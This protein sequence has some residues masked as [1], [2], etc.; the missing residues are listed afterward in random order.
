MA[1]LLAI[2]VVGVGL[3]FAHLSDRGLIYWD[4]GKFGLEGIRLLT[5]GR[6][7]AGAHLPLTLG[8]AVGTAKPGHALLIA[9]AYAI[10]GIHDYAALYLDAAASVLQIWL[11]YLVARRLFNP[12]IALISA[13]LLSTSEYDAI[14]A[15]SILS[16]SDASVLLLLGVLLYLR[17]GNEHGA[18]SWD[19]R[20]VVSRMAAGLVLGAAFT[21]NYRL[22]VYIAVLLGIDVYLLA[23]HAM[24]RP[25]IEGIA[26]WVAALAFA[27]IAWQ[28]VD[29]AAGAQG[30][31]LFRNEIAH[32]P[33][34]YFAQVIYQLHQ[35]KQSVVRFEPLP[36]L[37]WYVVRQGWYGL[38]LLLGSLAYAGVRRSFP[39]VVAAA[40]VLVPYLVYITAPFVVPRN[41]NAAMPFAAMSMAA[42]LVKIARMVR[43]A[44]AARAVVIVATLAVASANLLLAWRI[45]AVRSGLAR[46]AHFVS[47]N[48]SGRAVI[49]NEIMVFYLRGGPGRCLAP[50]VP[51]TVT[52][53]GAD[54]QSGFH[55]AVLDQYSGSPMD[56]VIKSRVSPIVEFSIE[57]K[58]SL[59]ESLIDSEN[60]LTPNTQRVARVVRVYDL[61]R[62]NLPRQRDP[63]QPGCDR[64]EPP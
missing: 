46:A 36:Y 6:D 28:V 39:L 17:G 18:P 47:A 9:L 50:R 61:T 16:E 31:V 8:K 3:R 51:Y 10:F 15:R 59:G 22:I 52:Q 42:F 41:L 20:G 14:Y 5:V 43:P 54:I 45:T 7:I 62:L 25:V 60:T 23:R 38:A 55:Y 4:E 57:G 35:G 63:R 19:S 49:A 30:V 37:Q 1:A 12:E 64:E 2:I 24:T 13:L 34:H 11:T 21:V 40:F 58:V 44:R 27:P 56:H 53:L 26:L 32:R 33:T 29:F 48:G